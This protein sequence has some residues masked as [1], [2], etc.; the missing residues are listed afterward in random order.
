RAG[1]IA[2]A[3][4]RQGAGVVGAGHMGQYHILVYAE[5][6]DIELAGVVDVDRDRATRVAAH[7]DTR[8]FA[9][10]RDLIGRVDLVSVA[11]PTEQHFQVASDFLE[12]G[13]S[14]LL[15]KPITP[16]LEEARALFASARPTSAGLRRA[17]AQRVNGAAQ[18]R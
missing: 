2:H 10:H 17:H 13:G 7:Y 14:V 15:E 12:A 5:L 11:V 16:T 18:P 3:D 9:D 8:A 1:V 4:G 6:W